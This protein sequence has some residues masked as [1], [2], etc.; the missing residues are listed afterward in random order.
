MKEKKSFSGLYALHFV[1][2]IMRCVFFIIA[3]S[4]YVS[5]R[6]NGSHAPFGNSGG[7][8]LFWGVIWLIF[9]AEMIFRF[10]PSTHLGIGCQK[11]FK[12]N[13]VPTDEDIP[14]P[15]TPKWRIVLLACVWIAGNLAFGIL[16]L[17]GI[18]DAGILVLLSLLYSIGDLICLLFF[19]PFRDWFLKNRCCA[20]CAIYNW[21]YPMMFTP[22]IF[23]PH[24]YTWSLLLIALA[25]LAVWEISKNLHPERFAENTN[26]NLSCKNCK[27]KPCRH[28]KRLAKRK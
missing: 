19:C 23:L 8:P 21:D 5:A 26:A 12:R 25:L 15:I 2:F 11:Q 14:A 28:T 24:P 1:Q 20:D 27:D 9:F 18:I 22:F 3:A 4:L 6:I 7:L 10:L 17:L 13:F 16:Y